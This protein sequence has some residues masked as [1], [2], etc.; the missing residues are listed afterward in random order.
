MNIDQKEKLCKA[1]HNISSMNTNKKWCNIY[2]I[3]PLIF[4]K[5]RGKGR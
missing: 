5:N 2:T 3:C 4:N 1:S